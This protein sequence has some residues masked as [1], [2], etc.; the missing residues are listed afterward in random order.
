MSAT[1]LFAQ[2]VITDIKT[3]PLRGSETTIIPLAIHMTGLP[4]APGFGHPPGSFGWAGGFVDIHLLDANEIDVDG[5][6]ITTP[7]GVPG[8]F[9]PNPFGPRSANTTSVAKRFTAW[10][11]SANLS[12]ITLTSSVNQPLFDLQLHAKGSGSTPEGVNSDVDML[13]GFWNIWHLAN[14]PSSATIQIPESALWWVPSSIQQPGD[15]QQF[16]IGGTGAFASFFQFPSSPPLAIDP[17][18]HFIHLTETLTF[19]LFGGEG[20]AFIATFLNSATL[21]LEHVPEPATWVMLMLGGVAL[22]FSRRLRRKRL[23]H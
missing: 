2:G 5:L 3:Q 1:V 13:L 21:G 18:A 17:N 12:G 9:I 8:T 22:L 19:H 7:G 20:S 10:H 23:T 14:G 6:F 4:P 15:L 16:H 11:P